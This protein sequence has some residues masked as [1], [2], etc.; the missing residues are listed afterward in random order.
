[1]RE[2]LRLALGSDVF[3][4]LDISKT[5]WHV[6]ARSGGETLMSASFPP[7]REALNGLLARL[8][9][10]RVHSAYETGPF[11][12]GLH[13]WLRSRMVDSMV[14][15]AAHVPGEIGNRVKTD[16]RDG[17]KLARTLEAGLL[18]PIFIP[19]ARQR[20]DRELVRQ[21]HRV[22][23]DRCASMVRIKSFFLTYDI[24][25]PEEAGAHWSGGFEAW[26]RELELSDRSL[27]RVLEELRGLYFDL[28]ARVDALTKELR[29]MARSEDYAPMV[30]LLSTVPGIGWLTALTLVVEI[31]DFSRFPDG[32]ALSSY[33]GLTPSERSSGERIRHGHI[34]RQGNPV[35][36]S[37]LVESSWVLIGKDPEMRRFYDRIKVRRG[38]KRA[39][40]AVARKL[41]HRILAI[42]HNGTPYQI[43]FSQN[44]EN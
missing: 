27:H 14:V 20:A 5:S 34:T 37:V 3:L 23:R 35:V 39:I 41:C 25:I 42:A 31:V 1:M 29:Q 18:R 28:D 6:T 9:G 19:E 32:E 15:S 43:N 21:R 36:R 38:G 17:L 26:L 12:Y 24:E 10:C 8:K 44:K 13:D 30:E 22:Q 33:A 11:G 4:G 7:M 2:G 40:V 16:R